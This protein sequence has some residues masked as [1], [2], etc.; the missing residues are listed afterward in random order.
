M[1][2]NLDRRSFLRLSAQF[3]AAGSLAT[4]LSQPLAAQQ[5]TVPAS[6]AAPKAPPKPPALPLEKVQATV[7]QAHRS[8][9]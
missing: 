5:P 4:A 2:Q 8:L 7:V 3:A 6:P 9:D 1:T